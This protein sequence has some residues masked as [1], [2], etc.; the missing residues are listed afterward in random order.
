M[1]PKAAIFNYFWRDKIRYKFTLRKC[2]TLKYFEE[3][4]IYEGMAYSP[5][6]PYST[7]RAWHPLLSNCMIFTL[8]FDNLFCVPDSKEIYPLYRS[9]IASIH[10]LR[11]YSFK[12]CLTPLANRCCCLD[13]S[14]YVLGFQDSLHTS[15]RVEQLWALLLLLDLV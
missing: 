7:L 2:Q 3:L 12:I 4:S 13:P 5:K 6:F 10:M 9:L 8:Y 1:I 11:L 15:A 14:I